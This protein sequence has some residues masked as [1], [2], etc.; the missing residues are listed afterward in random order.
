MLK[1]ISVAAGLPTQRANVVVRQRLLLPKPELEKALL[2]M[3]QNNLE[4]LLA[5]IAA[6]ETADEQ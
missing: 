1:A 2:A 6:A 4:D 5:A 3:S